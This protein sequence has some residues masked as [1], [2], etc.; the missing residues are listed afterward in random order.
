MRFNQILIVDS[1]PAGERNTARLLH[2]DL[3]LRAQVY[4]PTPEVLYRRL[5]CRRQFL[6]LLLEL[7]TTALATGDIPV[8]HIE[9]HGNDDGLAF[10]DGSFITWADLKVPLTS[11][12]VAT[13]MNLLVVV[14][15][16]DGSSLTHTLGLVDRAPLHGLIGPIRAVTPDELMRAYLALYETLMR[17]R[18]ASQAVEAMR[19]ATPG[20]F[21]YRAAKSLFQYVWDHYQ[22]TQ[23][24]PEARLERGRRMAANPPSGYDGPPV[25]PEEF[26]QLLAEKNR[27]FFD[28]YR[29]K[30]FLCDLFPEH[31]TRFAVRYEAPG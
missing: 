12:N 28:T 6:A 1:I 29:R 4:A 18:S 19:V 23:E 8:L 17:T 30:F 2:Q 5:D 7:T 9:C 27:E 22:A 13:G 20:T 16:C 25:Q 21:V 15:A 3:E 14:S 26:A 24:T 11:L 31:E 10:A